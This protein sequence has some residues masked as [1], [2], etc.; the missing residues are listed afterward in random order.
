M[1]VGRELGVGGAW[2]APSVE[3]AAL[4]LG[5]VGS[6]PT[7]QS[8]KLCMASAKPGDVRGETGGSW[9]WQAGHRRAHTGVLKAVLGVDSFPRL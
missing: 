5:I 7:L 8:P 2:L 4:D 6:S 9:D 3:P 1:R